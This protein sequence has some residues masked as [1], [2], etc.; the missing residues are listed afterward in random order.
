LC[1]MLPEATFSGN[2]IC[3]NDKQRQ[4]QRQW[5]QPKQH[6]GGGGCCPDCF[7]YRL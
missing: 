4:Q 2:G 3:V 6:K 7:L 5:Q 1:T